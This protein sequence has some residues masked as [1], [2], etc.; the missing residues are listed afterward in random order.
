MKNKR[1]TFQGKHEPLISPR[2]FMEVQNILKG[3][4]NTQ[5]N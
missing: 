1:K 2:M 3:K 4:T 5:N